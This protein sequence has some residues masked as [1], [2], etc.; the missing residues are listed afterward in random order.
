[1]SFARK[2]DDK[3]EFASK[4]IKY[5]VSLQQLPNSIKS[6]DN[7]TTYISTHTH[8]Y[9][10]YICNM[11]RRDLPDMYARAQGRA[12]PEGECGHILDIG[13]V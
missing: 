9:T 1:M 13:E 2:S 5:S 12:A 8:K 7:I 6:M 10:C 11:G 4:L 3:E